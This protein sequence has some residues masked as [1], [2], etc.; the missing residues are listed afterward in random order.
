MTS[1]RAAPS[2]LTWTSFERAVKFVAGIFW[3][4]AE[5]GRDQVRWEVFA[6]ILA[7]WA[8]TEAP[9]VFRGLIDLI[10]KESPP[11]AGVT[12]TDSAHS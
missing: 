7:I 10:R 3:A 4:N 2:W 8:G 1:D 11:S 5:M 12:S 9:R 6:F